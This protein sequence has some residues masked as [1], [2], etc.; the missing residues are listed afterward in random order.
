[1]KQKHR[2][3]PAV[4]LRQKTDAVRDDHLCVSS[5]SCQGRSRPRDVQNVDR[6]C[7]FISAASSYPQRCNA[8]LRSTRFTF[9]KGFS[10]A[11]KGIAGLTSEP[12]P[13]GQS[14]S[15]SRERAHAVENFKKIVFSFLF[16]SFFSCFF[17]FNE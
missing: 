5:N 13:H 10:D 17:F 4:H 14:R 2:C 8:R 9:T 15:P 12:R 7:R 6:S 11:N 3:Q 16:S 1:M